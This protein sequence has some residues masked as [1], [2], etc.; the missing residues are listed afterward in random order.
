MT[1]D[2]AEL[3]Q[4]VAA[5]AESLGLAGYREILGRIVH[6]GS[7]PGSWVHEWSREAAA[8]EA[9]G[10]PLEASQHY[11]FARF[12]FVDGPPRRQALDD[13]VRTVDVWR[14]DVL[15]LE[16]LD[17]DLPGGR[18]S[19]WAIDLSATEPK[20]LLLISGGIVSLK[21]QWAPVLLAARQL[22]LAGV[23]TEMP[24]VG[25]N[26]ITYTADSWHVLRAVL[27]AVAGRVDQHEVY[28]MAM[29]FSGQA[30]FRWAAQDPRVRGIV[31][32]GAPVH[33]PF[34]D[35]AWRRRLPKVTLDTLA[36]MTGSADTDFVPWALSES[37]LSSVDVPVHYVASA[38]DEIIPPGDLA[39]LR[40]HV[41]DLHVLEHDDV[42]GAP[43][44]ATQTREWM[45][46][47]LVEMRKAGAR[48]R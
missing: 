19:A 36:H 27:D 20:P 1:N 15:G 35:D 40:A 26:T 22:G 24:G 3:K 10:N 47:S 41:G 12:P 25:E 43:A 7:G 21:E 6:D 5:H 46:G 14:R 8:L 30:A 31:T 33:G 13:C 42:H 29:S 9:A 45:V 11:N 17:F 4:Y 48:R 34:A 18:A 38:R 37:E 16:R 23:V 39:L 2:L 28:V 44:H 32:A